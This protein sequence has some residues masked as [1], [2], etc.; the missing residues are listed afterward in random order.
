MR[1]SL[2]SIPRFIVLAVCLGGLAC[3]GNRDALDFTLTFKDAKNLQP[4]QFLVYKGIRVGEVKAVELDA[5]GGVKVN[6][7]VDHEHRAVV[8]R[9]ASFTIE[10][11]NGLTDLSGERQI[12]MEDSGSS[13][14]PVLQGDVL[15]GSEGLLD[16]ITGTVK[17]VTTSAV[18]VIGKAIKSEKP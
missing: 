14:T 8:Y 10:K 6:V 2:R 16:R 4:G 3:C 15:K 11:P 5:G 13:R 17:D 9:E 18:D 7:E 12:T 1:L